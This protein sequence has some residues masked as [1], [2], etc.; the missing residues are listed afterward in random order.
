MN[1]K[2]IVKISAQGVLIFCAVFCATLL[3]FLILDACGILMC[4][5]S[6][7]Q[8]H[9]FNFFFI[10]ISFGVASVIACNYINEESNK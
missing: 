9:V 1:T 8:L 2:T 3:P 5:G 7:K 10:V 6:W 4:G